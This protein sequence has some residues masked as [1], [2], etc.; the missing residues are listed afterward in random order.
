MTLSEAAALLAISPATLRSQIRNGAVKAVKHGRDWW[1]EPTEV[2]RYRAE[3]LG[4]R[5]RPK[6]PA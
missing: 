5:G 4:R 6:R 1:V 2:A 3:S